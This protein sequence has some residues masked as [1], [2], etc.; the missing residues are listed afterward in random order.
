M[1][2]AAALTLSVSA[3]QSAHDNYVGVNFGGGLNTMLYKPANGQQSVGAGFEA[4]I[5]YARF[6][7]QWAGLGVGFQYSWANA[8]ATY[9]WNEVT[10]GLTHPSN[11]NTPYNLTTG[12]NNFVER[13]N[14]GVLSIPVEALY[15]HPF[16]DRWSLLAGLGLADDAMEMI[17]HANAEK[18]LGITV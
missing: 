3:Q 17:C 10:T 18:L 4:G 15:R 6:F 8:Y 11:P 13:Q 9:N 1:F 7:N 5:H 14:V 2:A 16:N 12:F